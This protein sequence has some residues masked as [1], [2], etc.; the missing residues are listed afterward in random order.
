M[1]TE[2]DMSA[3]FTPEQPLPEILRRYPQTRAVLDRYGLRGCGGPDGPAETLGFFARTHGVDLARLTQELQQAAQ[4]TVAAPPAQL[5]PDLADIIYR[6][7]FLTGLA[8]LLLA[9]A[10][11]GLVML[12]WM[13]GEASY[14][15][16]GVRR[17]NAHAN[18]MVYGFAGMFI[19]GFGYQALPRFRHVALW[20]PKLALVSFFLLL[21]GVVLRF[22][23][24]FF[25]QE[26]IYQPALA[27]TGFLAGLSGTALQLAAFAIFALVMVNTLRTGGPLRTYE[28]FVLA[29]V[30]WFIA[31]L[32]FSLALFVRIDASAD[33]G[34]LVANVATYQES[35]RII[36]MFGAIGLIVLG[37][38]LRFAPAVFGFRDPGSRLF[39]R[40]FLV[41]NAGI[42][43]AAVAFPLAM[44]ARREEIALLSENAWRGVYG[45]G[46]L[47]IAGGFLAMA[48]G[49]AP[50]RRPTLND[51]S[52][53]FVRA[54][55]LWLAISLLL[56]LLEPLF[57]TL[58][59]GGFGHGYHSGMRHAFTIGFMTMM[60]VAV[61]A[62]VVPTLNGVD[63]SRLRGLWG[64][65]ALLNVALVWRVAGEI[66]G[67]FDPALLKGLHWSAS[68]T[69]VALLLWAGHLLRVII[70]PP[71]AAPEGV[72]D[73]TPETKVAAVVETWPRTMEVFLRY[74]FTTLTNPVARRTIA[75]GVS[76]SHVCRM[77][78]HDVGKF[79]RE[80]R[81]A[82]GLAQP[83]TPRAPPAPEPAAP[84][85]DAKASVAETARAHPA[86]VPVFSRLGMDACCGG[87]ESIERSAAHG[88]HDLGD[89]LKQ[90]Q[91]AIEEATHDTAG[92][93][94]P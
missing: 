92:T 26:S 81:E 18:A 80:L 84:P 40:M 52:V 41:V 78:G 67:D 43:I 37:V 27:P 79:V 89:V 2:K 22:S 94:R 72:S 53:K 76:L 10:L 64:V 60:I 55:M 24:E 4:Q 56:L 13:G 70:A 57:I 16:P 61:T 74:G 3:N 31:S 58:V 36:Q 93:T 9:G 47:L 12:L 46:V 28:R 62:K 15:A 85:V 91:E 65:F 71:R 51:R 5:R 23:G 30:F 77:H 87:A 25:G 29:S 88:G 68:L 90:L 49:F 8:V 83:A 38:M 14:F 11:T 66:A 86:T 1:G 6:P 63:P 32:A 54:A 44:L 21:G 73:I 42:V 7:F 82:A 50:W 59:L 45:L 39:R 35:L 69:T 34:A 19:M 20:R 17:M 33:F 75:R 48:A